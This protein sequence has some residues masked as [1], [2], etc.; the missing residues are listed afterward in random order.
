MDA[1]IASGVTPIIR[2]ATAEDAEFFFALDEQTT[3]ESLPR[4]RRKQGRADFSARLRRTLETMLDQPGH[5]VFIACDPHSGEKLGLL[6]FGP[7][8]NPV[9]GE[10][11]A[12]IYNLT[13]LEAHQKRGVGKLLL[14]HAEAHAQAVG[15]E[16]V[17]LVVAS[18]NSR[19][20]S[21]YESAGYHES[22]VLMR[23]ALTG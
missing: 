22:N 18:H 1:S 14:Q 2:P 7:R 23:K 12:W 17:G 3:W 20:R 4:D 5:V 21:V 19:A 9:S 6:W 13:V 16:V 11:E 8:F 10:D 15:F